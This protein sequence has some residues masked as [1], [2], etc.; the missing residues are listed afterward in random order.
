MSNPYSELPDYAFWRRAVS[1]LEHHMVDPITNP[2]FTFTPE[3]LVATAGSCFAQHISSYLRKHG[4]SYLVTE[5]GEH[6]NSKEQEEEQYGV[7]SARFG[8]IYTPR[9]LV[10]L[11]NEAVSGS[12]HRAELAWMRPDGR[13][14]DPYRPMVS[15]NGFSSFVDVLN[16]RRKHLPYVKQMFKQADIFVFTLGLT[17]AWRNK[18]DGS[19]FPL[20]P[21]VVGGEYDETCHEAV[22]FTLTEVIQDLHAFI[23]GLRMLNPNI[24]V[25]LTVSPVPLIATFE[26]RHVLLSTTYSKSLL[27]VAAQEIVNQYSFVDYFPSYE[28]ITG[29]FNFGRYYD[30]DAREVTAPG[31]NHVMRVFSTHYLTNKPALPETAIQHSSEHKRIICD[32]EQINAVNV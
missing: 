13:W 26:D 9:Q 17:E 21:G 32:E 2:R 14:I 6:L 29:S 11:F 15:P 1:G 22:N 12:S 19:V 16:A 5:A 3:S 25:L 7:F 28:L 4:F 31:V 23:M 20:A 30:A 18:R 8:N 24:K 27:R 10:Q